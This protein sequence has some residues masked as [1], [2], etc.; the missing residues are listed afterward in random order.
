MIKVVVV[1]SLDY[2]KKDCNLL[3]VA[4]LQQGYED[5][6][7]FLR[8][9]KFSDV[10]EICAMYDFTEELPESDHVYTTFEEAHG[11][12]I[13]ETD[14]GKEYIVMVDRFENIAIYRKVE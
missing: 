10:D 8:D 4:F 14:I 13:R 11:L 7:Q 6:Y 1:E 2:P 3:E 12:S 5:W 9:A